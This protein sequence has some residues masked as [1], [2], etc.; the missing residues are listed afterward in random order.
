MTMPVHMILALVFAT[1]LVGQVLS[2]EV[3]KLANTSRIAVF[4]KN[5]SAALDVVFEIASV[6]NKEEK[7][8]LIR[9]LEESENFTDSSTLSNHSTKTPIFIEKTR[10]ATELTKLNENENSTKPHTD[11]L[12]SVL[13]NAYF[14]N[15]ALSKLIL[16]GGSANTRNQTAI[17]STNQTRDTHAISQSTASNKS[18]DVDPFKNTT[19]L[20]SSRK[21]NR[22]DG[23]LQNARELSDQ[24]GELLVKDYAADTNT[25]NRTTA[26][27]LTIANVSN[28][29]IS[30]T[31]S[32]LHQDRLSTALRNARKLNSALGV[33]IRDADQDSRATRSDIRGTEEDQGRGKTADDFLTN[34]LG[35]FSKTYN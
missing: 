19:V 4:K 35:V 12:S 31:N 21:I 23:V 10:N 26:S 6:F 15:N 18:R 28:S 24:L 7:H 27:I 32:S 22:M 2:I 5:T 11:R 16:K 30:D 14:I 8:K 3:K 13:Q 33:L 29:S 17:S 34:L 20:Q 1:T 25:D 9:M